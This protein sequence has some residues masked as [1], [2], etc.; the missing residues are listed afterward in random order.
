MSAV[1]RLLLVIS[2][3]SGLRGDESRRLFD[4]TPVSDANPVVASIDGG[5]I[6]ITLGELRGYREAERL[7]AIT[8]PASLAQKRA[9]LEDLLK[10]YLF[11][12]EAYR[13]GVPESPG[14]VRQME[15]TRT[16]VL[17][18]FMSMRAQQ[19]APPAADGT[20]AAAALAERLFE[21]TDI[22]VSNE[23]YEVFK[24]GARRVAEAGAALR[25]GLP[26]AQRAE[27]EENMRR[28]VTGTPEAMLVRYADRTIS[29]RQVLAIYAGL[30]VEKR[31]PVQTPEGFIDMIKPLILPE[32]MVIEA[33][34]RGIEAE[35]A[36]RQKL[37]QNR[38]ALLRF[39]AHGMVER[40]ANEL[41]QAPDLETRLR[42]YHKLYQPF[43][44]VGDRAGGQRPATYEES[45]AQVEGDYSVALRDR[46]LAEQAGVLRKT[47]AVTINE[48]VLAAL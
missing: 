2:L 3:A 22:V 46:L 15:A 48:N 13:T 45:R 40:R 23:A 35:P 18:D 37:I 27:I 20:D 38:N 43:Y 29:L 17:S 14:F 32:L 42:A 47:R 9:V 28:V 19:A 8:D 31:P 36:F 26:P 41:L 21:A 16:M 5:R 10:E 7:N 11:V 24:L 4:F 30:P 12:D 1:T 6:E 34:K 44:V 39:H 33:V 25:P